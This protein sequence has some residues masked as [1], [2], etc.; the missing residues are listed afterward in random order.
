MVFNVTDLSF[1]TQKRRSKISGPLM[2]ITLTGL[3]KVIA[4]K[5]DFSEIVNFI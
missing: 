3:K 4:R 1:N 5:R 2:Q